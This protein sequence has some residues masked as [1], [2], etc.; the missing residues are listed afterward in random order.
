MVGSTLRPGEPTLMSSPRRHRPVTPACG[1]CP[2]RVP[3]VR[4]R[5]GG[6]HQFLGK[7]PKTSHQTTRPSLHQPTR[8]CILGAL[9]HL[10]RPSR[11][12]RS[13]RSCSLPGT[14]AGYV[15][16]C[17]GSCLRRSRG[18]GQFQRGSRSDGPPDTLRLLAQLVCHSS[19]NHTSLPS[20]HWCTSYPCPSMT[21]TRCAT[22]VR[23]T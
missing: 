17:P 18:G 14:G 12:A 7:T 2:V 11:R 16:P 9:S 4:G 1:P 13:S 23:C 5:G 22:D 8:P 10:P 21:T 6:H 19:S 3:R 15:M 20:E